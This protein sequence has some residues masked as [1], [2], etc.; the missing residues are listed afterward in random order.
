MELKRKKFLKLTKYLCSIERKT[1]DFM[2]K[3]KQ[4]VCFGV[5]VPGCVFSNQAV[6]SSVIIPEM[7]VHFM[8]SLKISFSI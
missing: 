2:I 1:E 4:N 5:C 8:I 3:R 6:G 7:S